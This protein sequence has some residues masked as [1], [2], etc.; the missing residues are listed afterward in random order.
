MNVLL[1]YPEFPATY[2]SFKH[3]LKFV[4]KR[5]SF[6]PLGLL[7]VAAML[8]KDWNLR[9]VDVNVNPL[10]DK[11]LQWADMALISGMVVQKKSAKE[12]I[13]RCKTAGVRTVCGGP[14]FTCEPESFPEADHLVLNE[15]ELTLPPFLADL[16][17]GTPKPR[18][19]SRELPDLH[20][21]PVPRW[22]LVDMKRYASMSLQFSRG[23]PF[24]CEFCNVTA[25]FGHRPRI[26]TSAQILA[27]LDAIHKGGW[28]GSIFFV[29]DN[30]IGNK[31][32][33]RHDLLPALIKWQHADGR[34]KRIPF[35]TEASINLADDTDL[36]NL[37]SQAG[38]DT[39]FVGIETPAEEGLAEC[40][41]KQNKGRD[42]I[43]C[44]KV[45]QRHGL[46]VQAGFIVGFDSDTATI[47]QRQIDFI[48]KSGIVMAMVGILQAPVGTRLYERM[49]KEGRLLGHASG[50]NANGATNIKLAM[51]VD[52]V[53]DGYRKIFENIYLP[54]PYYQRVKTFLKEYKRPAVEMRFQWSHLLGFVRSMIHLGL[55]GRER[56]QYWRLLLW[57]LCRRAD[58]FPTA[59]TLA[60][61]GHHFRKVYESHA[62]DT[63]S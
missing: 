36:M 9:L 5:S 57:T 40:N 41:K 11:D 62:Y 7:T 3:A 55:I 24:D 21:T 53:T 27:E 38:F 45:I 2:W 8:P 28:N 43:E 56:Y 15:A 49:K 52:K 58:L 23:C 30:F 47:F 1:I 18:Y 16:R 25:L 4:G 20:E 26:K 61:V 35:F 51:P 29:D 19:E 22:D 14:L 63:V 31:R 60:I 48:Q 13:G 46:Q 33:L 34:K 32:F 54:K 44:V 39:V 59:V 17:L 10:R 42:L 12:I 50:D 6:P 37:M